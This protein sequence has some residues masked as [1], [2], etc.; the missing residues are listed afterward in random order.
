MHQKKNPIEK[1]AMRG[2]AVLGRRIG[3]LVGR[4][5]AYGDFSNMKKDKKK[6]ARQQPNDYV[7]LDLQRHINQNRHKS[8][9]AIQ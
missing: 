8:Y 2:R 4:L 3:I 1:R 6:W 7:G 5:E 9:G